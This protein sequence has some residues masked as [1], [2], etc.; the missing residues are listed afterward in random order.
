MPS[1]GNGV[2]IPGDGYPRLSTFTTPL[3]TPPGANII[4]AYFL[5]GIAKKGVL[6]NYADPDRPLVMKGN[7]EIFRNFA[8]CDFSNCFD[9]GMQFPTNAVRF[10]VI[11]RPSP[12]AN[13]G[14]AF[15]DYDSAGKT[16][17]AKGSYMDASLSGKTVTG[18]FLWSSSTTG[19]VSKQIEQPNAEG[20]QIF[21]GAHYPKSHILTSM[22][23][24]TTGEND[25]GSGSATSTNAYTSSGR[26]ILIG[27]H[28]DNTG[29][30]LGTVDVAGF[31][32]VSWGTNVNDAMK[33][34]YATQGPQLG[35]WR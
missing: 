32:I 13:R 12:E 26:N 6:H 27:G 1:I 19:S 33:W 16:V 9:T 3:M 15:S 22:Y 25:S 20:F 35:M 14:L 11:A 2:V 17:A 24:M 28:Y 7:P 30:Y 31:M 34:L 10:I 21:S 8:R 4:S 5:G 23:N 29:K 18:T